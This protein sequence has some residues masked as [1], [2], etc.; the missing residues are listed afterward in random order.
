MFG[1]RLLY[2]LGLGVYMVF[3]IITG[4]LRVGIVQSGS[5]EDIAHPDS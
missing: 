3:I 5:T 2:F 1:R 4:V